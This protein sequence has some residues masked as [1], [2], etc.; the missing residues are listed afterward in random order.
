GRGRS[1]E[2]DQERGQDEDG[3]RGREPPD[4]VAPQEGEQAVAVRGVVWHPFSLRRCGSRAGDTVPGKRRRASA[5]RCARVLRRPQPSR[6]DAR[7]VSASAARARQCCVGF[8]GWVSV[9]I[10]ASAFGFRTRNSSRRKPY[11]FILRWSVAASTSACFALELMPPR[12]FRRMWP[13]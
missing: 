4:L 10:G 5:R 13:R 12:Y 9:K 2:V 7:A 3:D 8:G 1:T 11:D 6:R